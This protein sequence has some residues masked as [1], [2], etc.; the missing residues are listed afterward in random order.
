MKKDAAIAVIA[1][2]LTGAICYALSQTRPNL[3][4]TPSHPFSTVVEKQSAQHVVMRINGEEVTEAEFMAFYRQLPE[5]LQRQYA[6][7][8]GK[9]A[10]AEQ[11]IRMKLLEQEARK[12]GLERDPAVAGQLAA[13]NANVLANAAAEKLIAQP[14]EKAVQDFYAKNKNRFQSVDLSHI[15]IA[16]SNGSIPPRSGPPPSLEEG[17]KKA[18]A[19]YQQLK[20]GAD[21]A[22]TARKLSDD[23]T[24][25][26]AGGSIGVVSHGMLPPDLDQKVFATA[27]GQITP[28]LVSSFGIH[29]FRVNG[30]AAQ[31]LDQLHAGIAQRVRQQ[32]LVDRVEALRRSAKVDF[33]PKF[34][35]TLPSTKKPG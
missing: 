21:F 34:F 13:T 8:P 5:E 35:K 18:A 1:I 15:L 16:Y 33:D 7:E 2:A 11:A 14:N 25:A 30:R 10:L 26:P 29:I 28:P 27:T 9:M 23:T 22:A 3:P 12:S 4:P 6:N 19:I 24:T 20:G 32:Q 17:M 31:S